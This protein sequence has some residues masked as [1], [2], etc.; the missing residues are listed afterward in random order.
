MDQQ[1]LLAN[2]RARLDTRQAIT[3]TLIQM[4]YHVLHSA[5][6]KAIAELQREGLVGTDWDMELGGYP[7]LV[8]EG[9]KS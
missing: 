9:V 4:R 1:E 6:Q 7:I 8:K 5:A 2:V 3:A